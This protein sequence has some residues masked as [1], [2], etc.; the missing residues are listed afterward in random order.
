MYPHTTISPSVLAVVNLQQQLTNIG[1]CVMIRK[2]L[3]L[4]GQPNRYR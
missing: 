4:A 3:L 1:L 2:T